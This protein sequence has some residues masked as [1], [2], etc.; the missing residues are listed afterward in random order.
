MLMVI[1]TLNSRYLRT[2]ARQ[3]QNTIIHVSLNGAIIL[4]T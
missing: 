4:I 1:P 2:T 3:E